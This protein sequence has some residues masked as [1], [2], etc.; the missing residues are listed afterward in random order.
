MSMLERNGNEYEGS[1]NFW[2]SFTD[3]SL[4]TILILIILYFAQLL[5]NIEVFELDRIKTKMNELECR[6]KTEV[7]ARG[8]EDMLEEISFSR[9][10]REHRLTF[11]TSILFQSG[12]AQLQDRGVKT[13]EIV[14]DVLREAAEDGLL[15]S[16]QVEGHTD[17]DP[18]SPGLRVRDNWDLASNRATE[19]V[20]FFDRISKI[21]PDEVP[22]SGVGFSKFQPVVSLPEYHEMVKAQLP[23]GEFPDMQELKLQ[24]KADN[25]RV[26]LKLYYNADHWVGDE[27]EFEGC[28]E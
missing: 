15:E 20:R 5:S 26:E 21:D 14:G 18:V 25:R 23:A 11:S 24:W 12:S 10:Y 28:Y 6:I 9:T 7:V 27:P 4:I 22:M 16:L 17:T 19:V 13:L 8:G 3:I 2:P 1:V